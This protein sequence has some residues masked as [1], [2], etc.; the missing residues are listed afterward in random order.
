MELQHT[1]NKEVIAI[2]LDEEPTFKKV[3]FMFQTLHKE[4][5]ATKEIMKASS[6][7]TDKK[8][9]ESRDLLSQSSLES[10]KKLQE[11]E[12]ILKQQMKEVRQEIGGIGRSQG[13]VAERYFFH[14]IKKNMQLLHI[15]LREIE[16][17]L[18][19]YRKELDLREEYDLVLTNTDVLVVVEIKYKFRK[20]EVEK[21]YER[22][23]PNF[24]LMFP[25]RKNYQIIGAIAGFAFEKEC[26]EL[27]TQYG[28]LVLTRE[29]KHLE[30]LNE[31][32][33][34]Y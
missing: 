29:G 3:W 17:N 13:E 31:N 32:I 11:T 25:E 15:D 22:K 33:K 30:I 5:Q 12:R 14:A 18:N 6:L 2:P 19:R 9:Q 1:E 24:R 16:R 10:E 26:I 23:L 8:F 21:F 4:M 34:L 7:E 20:M 27:A 28:F